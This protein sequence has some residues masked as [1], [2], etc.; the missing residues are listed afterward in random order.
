[1]LNDDAVPTFF[2][3]SSKK[4]KRD[5]STRRSEVLERKTLINNLLDETVE[6]EVG[7]HHDNSELPLSIAEKS[8]GTDP[9]VTVD[10]EIGTC[11]HTRSIRTQCSPTTFFP[12][13]KLDNRPAN[14]LKIK[15]NAHSKTRSQ[16]MVTDI[17]FP[18]MAVV[19]FKIMTPLTDV[20]DEIPHLEISKTRVENKVT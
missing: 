14:I 1:M 8:V 16:G 2:S 20:N 10:K 12:D 9:I 11:I 3:F 5:N 15:I 6:S 18:P 4:K 13:S 17:S 7:E 19:D